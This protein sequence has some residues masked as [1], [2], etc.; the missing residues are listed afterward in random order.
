[1]FEGEL[2][3][4]LRGG[5]IVSCQA[6]EDDPLS[7]PQAMARMAASVAV[8]GVVAI[9][10]EGLDDIA[11]IK[12]AVELPVIGLWKDGDP[13][14]V[15]ITPTLAHGLAV[16]GAGADIVALDSTMRRPDGQLGDIIRRLQY[17]TGTLVLA[18]VSTTEEGHEAVKAGADLVATTLSGYTSQSPAAAGADLRLVE[19]LARKLPVPVIAEGRIADPG[20]AREA[21]QRGAWAVVVGTAITR[22]RLIAEQFVRGIRGP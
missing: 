15:Y 22:P 18:D 12:A 10:A 13:A 2:L 16:A 1:M 4:A 19:R 9:R 17:D 20:T 11:A 21:L 6:P 14:D 8:P 3:Q 5:L 7:G